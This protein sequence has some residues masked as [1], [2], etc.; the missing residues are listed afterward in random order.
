MEIVFEVN[1]TEFH[2]FLVKWCVHGEG[3]LVLRL[4]GF[5]SFT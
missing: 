3:H 1:P 4:A 2:R 5:V